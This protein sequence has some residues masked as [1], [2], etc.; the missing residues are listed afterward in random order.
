MIALLG[1]SHTRSYKLANCVS[2]RIFL[3]PGKINN[4]KNN[5]N[6][7]FTILRYL[8]AAKVLKSLGCKLAFSVGESDVR[9][10]SY[11]SWHID[12]EP[13]IKMTSSRKIIVRKDS[14][15]PLVLRL[16][17][18]LRI[19]DLL[20]LKPFVVI[21]AGSPNPEIST[22]AEILNREFERVCLLNKVKFFN[23]Q[24]IINNDEGVIDS[25]Y[26]G[27]SVFNETQI[28]LT[29]LSV[30]ISLDFDEFIQLNFGNQYFSNLGLSKNNIFSV[31]FEEIQNFNT[32]KQ[33]DSK[34][35]KLIKYWVYKCRILFRHP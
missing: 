17:Y 2:T 1:D 21:G 5:I 6:T 23:P 29:H 14:L 32:F 16:K 25:S 11:G 31:K 10:L 27:Y 15:R 20:G 7:F 3:A 35:S 8:R 26:I 9:W 19:T 34:F 22:T 4:F 28:D 30:K 24:A 18:F 13:A 33:I 12:G